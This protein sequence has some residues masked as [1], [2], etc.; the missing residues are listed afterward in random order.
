MPGGGI[1]TFRIT[2]PTPF[3]LILIGQASR[4]PLWQVEDVYKLIFQAAQGS[5]HA[6]I[7]R[8]HART[9]LEQELAFLTPVPFS[10]PLIEPIN[11]D[12]SIVRLNLRP[13]ARLKLPADELLE[14]YVR[15]AAEYYG[16]TARLEYYA[17]QTL[18]VAGK[19]LPEAE[20]GNLEVFLAEMKEKGYPSVHHSKVYTREY[21]PAYR[22][23]LREFLPREWL[24]FE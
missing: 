13:F 22:V 17:A 11:T 24:E 15:T 21:A 20:A 6:M 8:E 23:I 2:M 14:I 5:E 16:S 3:Q 9:W 7:N 4:F 12:G 1:W 19:I 10:E 18:P